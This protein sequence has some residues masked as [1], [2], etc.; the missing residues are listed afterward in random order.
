M[1]EDVALRRKLTLRLVAPLALLFLI[2]SLDRANVSFAALRMNAD[3]RLSPEAYGLGASIFFLGYILFQAP[4]AFSQRLLGPRVWICATM[5]VWG[6]FA[7]SLAFIQ[8][9]TQFFVLRFLLGV[10]EGGFAPGVMAYLATWAP[11]RFRGWLIAGTMVA[12][13][14]SVILGGPLSGWLL[15]AGNPVGLAGWRWMFLVEGL[16]AVVLAGF[17]LLVFPNRLEQA[18]WLTAEE[19]RA[20]RDELERE[21]AEADAA[22][23]ARLLPA[24]AKPWLWISVL[25]WFGI[26]AGQYGLMFWLPQVIKAWSHASDMAVGFIAALP[27]IGIAS[28]MMLNAWHSDRTGER[29]LHLAVPAVLAAVCT[30]SAALVTNGPIA[31]LLLTTG[32]FFLGAAQ[33]AF[34][35]IPTRLLAGMGAMGG[36]TLINLC[37]N[38]AGV[39][40]PWAIGWVRAH[41]GS[42]QAPVIAMAGVMLVVAALMLPLRGVEDRR[43]PAATAAE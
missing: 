41:T 9:H 14:T 36:V 11:R 29:L 34:W 17:A 2:N 5:L 38:G 30:A 15:Q 40:T 22:G 24:L 3:L 1:V 26:L 25:V 32:G 6:G 27:W 35:P 19:K 10:A 31:L 21:H 18:R 20:L 42:F 33:G 4:H 43:R 37:G 39:V 28:G 8:G 16:P 23:G 12:I 13:P 7:T